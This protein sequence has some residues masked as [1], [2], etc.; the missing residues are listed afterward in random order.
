MTHEPQTIRTPGLTEE[1]TDL[2]VRYIHVNPW[3]RAYCKW[4]AHDLAG[5][6]LRAAIWGF[7]SD[8]IVR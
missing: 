6:K 7:I 3:H 8:R 5:H 4:Y 2:G 1:V